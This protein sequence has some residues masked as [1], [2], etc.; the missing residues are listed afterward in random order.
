MSRLGWKFLSQPHN[1]SVNRFTPGAEHP[2]ESHRGID[3]EEFPSSGESAYD[4]PRVEVVVTAEQLEREQMY[5]GP[6]GPG[7]GPI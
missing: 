6:A 2:M 7:Y 1:W 3:L 5:G 4:P